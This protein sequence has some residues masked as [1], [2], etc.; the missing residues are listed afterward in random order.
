MKDISIF[1]NGIWPTPEWVV[2]GTRGSFGSARIGLEFSPEW[3]GLH[4]RMTFF[5]ADGSDAVALTVEDGGVRVPDEVM[6]AAGTASYVI[7]GVREGEIFIS[8]RGELRVVDTVDPGG[9]EPVTRTPS[10]YDR[11]RAELQ[12]LKERIK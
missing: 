8:K 2:A 12:E 3:D 11:L 4:K 9:R 10:D 1:V 7:D 6:A 5:P